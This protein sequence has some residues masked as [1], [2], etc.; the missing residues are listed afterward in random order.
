M[1]FE[2]GKGISVQ[3]VTEALAQAREIIAAAQARARD[4]EAEAQKVSDEAKEQGYQEGFTKGRIEAS[5]LAVRIISEV[6][7]INKELAKQAAELALAV[8]HKLIAT[9]VDVAKQLVVSL[10]VRTL[11]ESSIGRRAVVLVNPADRVSIEEVTQRLVQAAEHVEIKIEIDASISRGG[12]IVQTEFGEI[13][14][15]IE[16]LLSEIAV[17]FGLKNNTFC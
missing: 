11:K 3:G 6:G 1:S 16:T 5:K 2:E 4:I 17:F 8:C 15:T 7:I 10:A 12:C 13:D 9:E 14:V